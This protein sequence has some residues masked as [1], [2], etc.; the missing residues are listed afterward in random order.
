MIGAMSDPSPRTE[1]PVGAPLTVRIASWSARHRWPVFV[2][3]FA[4]TLGLFGFSL[5]SG[6]T[7]IEPLDSG[8]DP[9][10][11]ESVRAY[12]LFGGAAR[13]ELGQ[14]YL[15][16]VENASATIDDPAFAEVVHSISRRLGDVRDEGGAP[17]L[18]Q[19]LDP[20]VAAPNVAAQVISPDRH[21]VRITARVIG[22]GQSLERKLRPVT[23]EV[24]RLRAEHPDLTM[25]SL[26]N[27]LANDEILD[28]VNEDL[29]RSLLLTIP[30]TFAILLIAFGAVVAAGVPLVLAGTSLAAAFGILNLYSQ[31]VAPVAQYASQ[32]VVLIGLAVSVD[33]SLFLVTRF[34]TERRRG[35]DKLEAIDV[36]SGTAGRAVLFSGLAVVLSIAGLYL[37]DDDTFNAMAT[38]TIAVVLIAVVG[39]LTF[40]PA[41][42]AILGRGVDWGRIPYF[43]RPREEGSGA[44]SSL[45]RAVSR[46]PV[47]SAVLSGAFLLLLAA[48]F[49]RLHVGTSDLSAFPSSLESVRAVEL[50]NRRWPGGSTVQLQVVVS[51]AQEPAVRDAIRD[52]ERRVEAIPAVTGP[53]ETTQSRTGEA[54]LLAYLL[55]GNRNDESN[56]DIV[57]AVREDVVPATFGAL[58]GVEA[59][60]T[61]NVAATLDR[62]GEFRDRLPRVLAF[63]LGLTFLLLLIAFRSIV[64]PLKAILLNLLSTGA[65]YG[66]LVLVFQDG[67]F[68]NA[69]GVKPGVVEDFVPLFIFTILFGLSMDYHVFILMRIK[70]ARDQ[71]LSSNE[72]V[73]R[74]ISI[75]SGT[76]TSAAAIMVCVFAVFVTL[77][78]AVV[79][80]IGLGLAVAVLLDATVVRSVLLPSTMRLLGEWNWWLPRWLQWM[81]RVTLEVESPAVAADRSTD[82][83]PESLPVRPADSPRAVART[84]SASIA[85]VEPATAMEPAPVAL[86]ESVPYHLRSP[87]KTRVLRAVSVVAASIG[88]GVAVVA[89]VWS[90]RRGF[91]R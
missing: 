65:A 91:R 67:W 60:V 73:V 23:A 15:L 43:G 3:W 32:L 58:S 84:R 54:V 86:A 41:T 24:T 40:L 70:E 42:L 77:R 64:I 19:V 13:P 2:L 4:C 31:H 1:R 49:L 69:L 9:S 71:G 89:A 36:A 18:Q 50:L 7:R 10:R 82:R 51:R 55:P 39:S 62:V 47:V 20:L 44:W 76:V 88:T 78:L 12:E 48:P 22:E 79:K 57:R 34:R 87:R 46:R 66:A 25:L 52:L 38:G 28:L 35:R 17:A 85:P 16:V 37:L 45:V 6:G 27:T 26:N 5:A 29:D 68:A 8:E 33:Y 83:T 21:A 61:G 74:G 90:A 53:A 81:P 63:V 72:S 30:L 14:Q 11:L 80:E 75:T 59:L 56:R